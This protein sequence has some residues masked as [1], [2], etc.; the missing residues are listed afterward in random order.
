[1]SQKI[2]MI[3]SGIVSIYFIIL[4]VYVGLVCIFLEAPYIKKGGFRKE[5]SVAKYGGIICIVGSIGLYLLFA[6]LR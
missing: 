5:E 1:M 2:I 6:F 4:S 3:G